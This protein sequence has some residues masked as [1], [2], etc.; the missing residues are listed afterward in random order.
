[1]PRMIFVNLPVKDVAASTRFYEALGFT[2]DARFSNEQASAMIWSDTISFMLL[3]HDFY[4]SFVPHKA[5]AD[6]AA[7]SAAILCLSRDSRAE[8]DAIVD[9]AIAAGGAGDTG[10]KQDLPF[11]YGRNFEDLDGHV[12]ETMWM[13]VDAMLAAMSPQTQA[14]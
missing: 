6:T 7:T 1:M 14:A 5:I 2:R 10:A 13:D 3:G 12:V 8:V 4:R 11:M 9:A